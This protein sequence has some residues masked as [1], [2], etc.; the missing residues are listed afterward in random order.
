MS[1]APL[2]YFLSRFYGV[3]LPLFDLLKF[4]SQM[5]QKQKVDMFFSFSW[6]DCVSFFFYEIKFIAS[7][8]RGM[9][10]FLG[11]RYRNTYWFT[12]IFR[13]PELLNFEQ[14]D[15]VFCFR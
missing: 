4:A 7:P 13:I 8:P 2:S 1:Y 15:C 14:V 3:I 10:D 6:K 5:Q 9:M 12:I 11:I